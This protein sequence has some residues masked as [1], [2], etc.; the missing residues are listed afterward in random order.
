MFKSFSK[1]VGVAGIAA[2][3]VAGVAT[4]AF[5]ATGA[6]AHTIAAQTQSSTPSGGAKQHYY[7][8]PGPGG[9]APQ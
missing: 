2:L 4:P 9:G 1:A 5:A 6:P 7:V 8:K 3:A